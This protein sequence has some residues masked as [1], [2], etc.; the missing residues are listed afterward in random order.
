MAALYKWPPVSRNHSGAAFFFAFIALGA[1]T[2]WVTYWMANHHIRNLWML[3]FHN[4]GHYI[5]LILMFS[6]WREK[7]TGESG[8]ASSPSFLSPGILRWSIFVYTAFW[9]V[10]KWTFERWNEPASYTITLS[11]LVFIVISLAALYRMVSR[12]VGTGESLT[13]SFQ[14]W[15]AVGI[16]TYSAGSAVHFLLIPLST[17]LGRESVITVWTIHW[18]LNVLVNALYANG[19]L[20]LTER[21][22]A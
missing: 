17:N 11:T 10:S 12:P 15:V 19:F 16:L 2:E 18:G 7:V 9:L 5:L 8:E 6:L 20:C 21:Q 3:H 1:L 14:F 13:R 4:L 22:T